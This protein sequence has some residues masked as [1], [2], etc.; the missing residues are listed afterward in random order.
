EDDY[1]NVSG[2]CDAFA[3]VGMLEH[4]GPEHYR[5]LGAVI[6]RCLKPAGLGLIHSIGRNRP[7]VTNPWLERRIFPGAYMPTL[8][9]MTLGVFEPA[10]FSVLDVENLR[11]HYA[12]TLGHW[13]R[14]FDGVA[15]RVGEKFGQRFV[16]TWRLY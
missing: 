11:L 3:S 13:L 6:R 4:V 16:R 5:E 9:E 15:D 12:R 1:R 8:A 14:R 10:G 2:T 7:C